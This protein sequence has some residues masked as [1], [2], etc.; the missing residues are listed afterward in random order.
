MR[1]YYV[2]SK[3]IFQYCEYKTQVESVQKENILRD[4]WAKQMIRATRRN[5]FLRIRIESIA[6]LS[7]FCDVFEPGESSKKKRR[8]CV[9]YK[10]RIW[11]NYPDNY[12]GVSRK[13][14]K[15]NLIKFL[16][17]LILTIYHFHL[18]YS[19]NH[20]YSSFQLNRILN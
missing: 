9:K 18:F 11:L 4:H 7:S 2:F 10:S 5:N 8:K 13:S 1:L 16:L 6:P 14:G 19:F 20:F 3:D 17:S 12:H 15:G